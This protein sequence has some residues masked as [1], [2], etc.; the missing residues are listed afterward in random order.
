MRS[1][2]PEILVAESDDRLARAI[3]HQLEALGYGT[4]R[5]T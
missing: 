4:K 3:A 1:Q 2:P 5:T